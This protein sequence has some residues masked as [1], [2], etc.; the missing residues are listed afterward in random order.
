MRCSL[1]DI[2]DGMT[3]AHDR[4][5]V[6]GVVI[7]AAGMGTRLGAGIP[8]A[9]VRVAGEPLV[10]HALRRTYDVRG[11]GAVVVVVPSGHRAEFAE[12]L[13][14]AG[15]D[16]GRAAADM[17]RAAPRRAPI[18]LVDGGAER[19]DSVA[20][21]L[22]ALPAACDIVLIH[23][24]ARA[25]APAA[26]FDAVVAAVAA[27]A[28]AVVPGIPVIDTIKQV[29]ESGLVVATPPRHRLRAVQT[30]QGFRRQALVRAHA[31]GI[32]ATDDAALVEA[33]GG[34]VLVIAGSDDAFKVT[35]AADL[36]RARRQ[37][38]LATGV[39]VSLSGLPGVGKSTLAR[40]LAVRA[41]MVH[42]RVDTIEQAMRD[43]GEIERPM[44]AG[45]AVAY[46]VAAD[47]LDRGLCV[48]ADSVNPLEATR[49]AWRQVANRSEAPVLEIELVCED[50]R[51]HERRATTRVSDIAGLEPPSWSAIVERDYEEY[52]PDLRLDTGRLTPQQCAQRIMEAIDELR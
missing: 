1:P 50:V 13:P 44:V 36:V 38:G 17:G 52:E 21:G 42:L 24:A 9:L 41:G 37:H 20:A 14:G 8:K 4:T 43:S 12:L 27:G 46:A 7:V 23:D 29:D 35:T 18:T 16:I 39:L 30:P 49:A 6:V 26:L 48:V 22:A 11:L 40:E 31:Q 32:Q 45:Y 25:F 51:E 33:T 3:D 15:A 19:T 28:D 2:L 47:Q 34:R 10:I 5:P